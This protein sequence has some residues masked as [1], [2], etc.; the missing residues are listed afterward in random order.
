MTINSLK[1]VIKGGRIHPF[2]Y[3][4]QIDFMW[5]GPNLLALKNKRKIRKDKKA[6]TFSSTQKAHILARRELKKCPSYWLCSLKINLKFWILIHMHFDW[7]GWN[8]ED[9]IMNWLF[10]IFICW[11]PVYFFFYYSFW[12][13]LASL[14]SIFNMFGLSKDG[15]ILSSE[16]ECHEVFCFYFPI[17]KINNYNYDHFNHKNSE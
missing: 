14:Q 1:K 5:D 3:E 15:W 17:E 12:W 4:G 16:L 11:N 13:E 8:S 7:R 9:I 10:L 6:T 2:F